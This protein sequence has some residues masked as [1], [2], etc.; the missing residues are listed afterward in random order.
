MDIPLALSFD[1]VLLVP[2]KSG[3]TSRSQVSLRTEIAPG[4]FL[5]APIIAIN[6]DT[7]TGTA[8]A[9]AMSKYGGIAMMPRFDLPEE[10]AKKI[11]QVKK[12]G[13]R[14]I[15]ALGLRDDVMKRA[16]ACVRAGADIFTIDVAHGHMLRCLEVTA[17]LKRKFK[18]PVISGVIATREGAEDLFKAGADGVRVGVG[19][20]TICVTRIVTGCGIPQMTALMEVVKAKRKFPDRFVLADGGTSSSGD[21]V[22]CLAAGASA[23]ICGSLLAGT[24]EAPGGV[25]E[26]EGAIYKEYNGSTSVREKERQLK[27]HNGHKPHFK[28]HIEGVEG[29]VPY[30]GPVTGVL[31]QLCAGIR[32]G[33]SYC[34]AQNIR[35]LWQKARFIQITHAGLL[36]SRAHGI[37]L[38]TGTGRKSGAGVV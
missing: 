10:Q 6:M 38:A 26:K 16:E 11:A 12:A 35:E 3:I 4:F 29:L 34:G 7:V 13:Q 9:I 25:V 5:D 33:F 37:E 30:R 24:D 31:E 21:M 32:S 2:Q 8:M 36:E 28:L 18:L 1:D 17:E 14:I 20:G 22:K 27:K 23:V 15:A 19:A